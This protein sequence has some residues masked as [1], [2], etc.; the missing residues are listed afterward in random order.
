MNHKTN[1][2]AD[3]GGKFT[4]LPNQV[5]PVVH[6][7]ALMILCELYTTQYPWQLSHK[8]ISNNLGIH[9]NHIKKHLDKL[10]DHGLISN[11]QVPVDVKKDFVMIPQSAHRLL[12]SKEL[13]VLAHIISKKSDEYWNFRDV[14]IAKELKIGASTVKLALASLES[15]RILERTD[16]KGRRTAYELLPYSWPKLRS[17]IFEDCLESGLDGGFFSQYLHHHNKYYKQKHSPLKD[18]TITDNVD[19]LRNIFD[20]ANHGTCSSHF[21]AICNRFLR[22]K[23]GGDYHFPV[24]VRWVAQQLSPDRSGFEEFT[25]AELVDFGDFSDSL[26]R[27]LIS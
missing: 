1:I 17:S 25:T 4:K 15:M 5:L 16:S 13:L 6:D 10:K 3:Y 12:S 14:R 9:R 27:N 11:N 22:S 2:Q 18:S 23:A 24:F 8:A 21:S 20:L 7:N 26:Y 19:H